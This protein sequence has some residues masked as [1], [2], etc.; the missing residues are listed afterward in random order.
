MCTVTYSITADPMFPKPALHGS[1]GCPP[2]RQ[3]G[4]AG[5]LLVQ[6]LLGVVPYCLK[7]RPQ[8]L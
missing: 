3:G 7:F 4:G 2:L 5:P 8:V 1:K 6:Y